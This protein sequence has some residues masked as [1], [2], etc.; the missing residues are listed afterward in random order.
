VV[1][2]GLLVYAA[3]LV[4]F[5][6]LGLVM[7]ALLL[8]LIV[9]LCVSKCYTVLVLFVFDSVSCYGVGVACLPVLAGVWFGGDG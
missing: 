1:C 8:G 9:L 5:D 3:V 6:L 4:V 7:S 2:V